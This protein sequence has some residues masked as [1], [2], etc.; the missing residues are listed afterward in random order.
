MP[1]FL[2]M[3]INKDISRREGFVSFRVGLLLESGVFIPAVK[4]A[5]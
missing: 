3:P 5:P 4:L 2:G 1:S